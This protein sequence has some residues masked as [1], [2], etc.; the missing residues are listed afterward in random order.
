MEQGPRPS[1]KLPPFISPFHPPPPPAA[2]AAWANSHEWPQP[3]ATGPSKKSWQTLQ[4]SARSRR[5]RS[6]CA[7]GQSSG[8]V[9]SIE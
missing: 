7:S 1:V 9:T 6:G 8:N 2:T 4:R 5:R 3:S